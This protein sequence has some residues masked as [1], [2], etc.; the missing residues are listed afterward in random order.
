MGAFRAQ[1]RATI[2][3]AEKA[4]ER[5]GSG[6]EARRPGAKAEV[7]ACGACRGGG[8]EESLR[9]GGAARGERRRESRRSGAI[10][11]VELATS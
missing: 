7:A 1:R 6:W 9:G 4:R 5:R 2:S 11:L 8:G 10:I 3:I